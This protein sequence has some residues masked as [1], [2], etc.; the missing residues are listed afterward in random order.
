MTKNQIEYLKA[1]ETARANRAT[2]GLTAA[3][4]L[5]SRQ[6]GIDTLKETARHNTQ[7]ELQARDNLAEQYRNNYAQ[8]QELQR[9]HLASE[10]IAKSQLELDVRKADEQVRHNRAT[11]A[12][13]TYKADINQLVG[14]MSAS[15]HT[16]AAGI[17]AAA[18]QYASDQA[19]LARQLEVDMQKY[20]IDTTAGLRSREIRETT[21]ANLAREGE[22]TRTNT[23]NEQIRTVT[24]AESVRH[25]LATELQTA[26]K[27]AA[28]IRIRNTQNQISATQAQTS[29]KAV[30]ANISLIPSQKFSNYARGINQLAS[31]IIDGLSKFTKLGG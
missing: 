18:S 21:R 5:A 23:A 26:F 11:E 4:D 12:I 28:D 10:G 31:P 19:L 13:D 20:N 25:D 30:D 9:S 1:Q 7:V 22:N 16:V 27:N 6:L 2:E 29:R 24:A 17:S 8:L 15:A 14:Q 3:R